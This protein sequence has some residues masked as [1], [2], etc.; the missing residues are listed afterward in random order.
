MTDDD[1]RHPHRAFDPALIADFLGGREVRA[2]KLLPCG[3]TNS[4]YRLR[5]SSGEECVLRLL[6]RGDSSREAHVLSLARAF[7]P[8]PEVLAIGD[9]WLAL[10]YVDGRPLQHTRDDLR[11][12]GQALA[13]IHSLRFDRA[14]WIEPDASV[15][16]FHFPDGDFTSTMLARDDVRGWL[17]EALAEDVARLMQRTAHLRDGLSDPRLV[18]GDFN[19]SNLL[20]CDGRLAAVLD[21]E[22]AH[23]GTRWMD[24]GNLLRHLPP[25][26]RRYV[27]EGLEAGG[28]ALPADWQAR[29][30]LVDLSSALEFLTS[31]RSDTFKRECVT[32]VRRVVA[33][34][35]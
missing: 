16:P 26:L 6:S 3:K 29:A 8:A 24:V 33:R 28:A 35:A 7:V 21:W 23:A 4:N 20:V 25:A 17:G 13:R 34:L 1:R 5:L 15:T 2:A 14:G 12:A 22:F 9:G 18:H 11:L 32:R 31:G 27:R 19:A 10:E 30:E